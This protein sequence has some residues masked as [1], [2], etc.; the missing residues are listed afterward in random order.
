MFWF[1]KD[2]VFTDTSILWFPKTQGIP[3][4]SIF[5][6]SERSEFSQNIYIMF[7]K[8][9]GFPGIAIL[10]F[11]KYQGFQIHFLIR[12]FANHQRCP[13]TYIAWYPIHQGVLRYMY[14]KGDPDTYIKIKIMTQNSLQ[15]H[16]SHGYI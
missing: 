14:N 4:K 11:S 9:Q 10:W 5:W 13:S 7:P 2:R 16:Y 8:S 3:G 1:P 6:F 15:W 12:W